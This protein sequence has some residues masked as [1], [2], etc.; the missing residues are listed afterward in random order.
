MTP[1]PGRF[2]RG[3]VSPR[4]LPCA[5]PAR[6]LAPALRRVGR[7]GAADAESEERAQTPETTVCLAPGGVS[8]GDAWL[9]K[10]ESVRPPLGPGV[11]LGPAGEWAMGR[12][13]AGS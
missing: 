1:I 2:P 3:R 4:P 5:V 6:A 9:P 8:R 13:S 11:C 12:V 7:R 10:A